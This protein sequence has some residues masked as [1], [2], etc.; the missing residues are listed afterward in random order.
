M[1]SAESEQSAL[2]FG[3]RLSRRERVLPADEIRALNDRLAATLCMAASD[4][5]DRLFEEMQ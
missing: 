4:R 1:P 3:L 2:V 5:P